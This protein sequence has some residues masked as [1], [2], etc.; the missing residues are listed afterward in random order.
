MYIS[1]QNARGAS[2]TRL[3][4]IGW[5]TIKHSITLDG[6]EIPLPEDFRNP[7]GGFGFV[8]TGRFVYG[9]ERGIIGIGIKTIF[10]VDGKE[11]PAYDK[12]DAL[13]FNP[14]G[15]RFAYGLVVS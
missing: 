8:K 3:C 12:V 15:C 6:K 5:L 1:E 4:A 7:A 13:Q 11:G 2:I 14:D 10:I 9:I